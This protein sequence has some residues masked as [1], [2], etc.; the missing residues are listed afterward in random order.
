VVRESEPGAARLPDHQVLLDLLKGVVAPSALAVALAF[1]LGRVRAG[2]LYSKFG[3]DLSV[4]SFSNT[5]YLTGSS[6]AILNSVLILTL[7][8][9]GADR[10]RLALKRQ[11]PWV[12][13]SAGILMLLGSAQFIVHVWIGSRIWMLGLSIIWLLGILVLWLRA[14]PPR[15]AVSPTASRVRGLL[16]LILLVHASFM[17]AAQYA[18]VLGDARAQRIIQGDEPLPNVVVF[19]EQDLALN[20]RGIEVELLSGPRFKWRYSNLQLLV[21][22]ATT[23]FLLPTKSRTAATIALESGPGLRFEYLTPFNEAEIRPVEVMAPQ[24]DAGARSY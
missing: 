3:L 20:H 18:V 17:A 19:S 16:L 6:A 24:I 21:K 12:T 15:H 4:L 22:T 5:D 23:Y 10:A 1:Y 11:G 9:L 13:G 7:A 8:A 14:A 2:R